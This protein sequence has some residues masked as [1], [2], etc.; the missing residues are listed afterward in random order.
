MRTAMKSERLYLRSFEDNK[1]D[2]SALY[3][4]ENDPESW[5]SSMTSN[6]VSAKF[7]REYILESATSLITQGTMTLAIGLAE[8]QELIGYL[9]FLGYDAISQRVGYGLYIAPEHRRKG[10]GREVI[11]LAEQYAFQ[12]LGVRLVYADILSNNLSCCKLFEVLGYELKATLPEWHCSQGSWHN[13]NY[14]MKW[15]N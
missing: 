3:Q 14:Y 9:Q 5:D 1:Q 12:H 8:T 11:Q 15:K 13:L 7:I 6:P 2:I 10:Y 4:W